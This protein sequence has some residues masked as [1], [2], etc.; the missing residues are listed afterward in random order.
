[1][2]GARR[3]YLGISLGRRYY[4]SDRLRA[5]CAW[6]L[7]NTPPPF[8]FLIG[9]D[10]YSYTLQAFSRL[11]ADEAIAR[12]HAKGSEV[13]T[14]LRRISKEKNLKA[15]IVRWAELFPMRRYRAIVRE[16]ALLVECDDS[17]RQAIREQAQSNLRER[18]TSLRAALPGPVRF[19]TLLEKYVI[20]EVAGLVTMSEDR[21]FPVE[22]YPGSDLDVLNRIYRG[23][24]G[25]LRELLPLQP[26]REFVE[27]KID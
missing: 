2:E 3:A 22:V 7:V 26:I 14:Q 25:S 1:M 20:H 24:W 15:E 4:S 10:I 23:E 13:V 27:L 5:Y 16:A 21:G 19:W 8:G 9:D 12:A 11:Q 17:F 6:A 18:I